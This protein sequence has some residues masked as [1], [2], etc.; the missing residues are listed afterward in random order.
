MSD[1]DTPTTEPTDP[2]ADIEAAKKK[3]HD[4]WDRTDEEID[5]LDK[6]G[7][8]ENRKADKVYKPEDLQSEK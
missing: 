8:D 1:I 2:N 6:L 3:S 5:R 7:E 4:A